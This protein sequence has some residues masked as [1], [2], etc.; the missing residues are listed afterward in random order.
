MLE[1]SREEIVAAFKGDDEDLVIPDL[2]D[3]PWSS[4]DYFGWVHPSGHL[5]F[6]VLQSPNDGQIRGIRLNDR[7]ETLA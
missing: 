7:R 3:I 4:L 1:L 6:V 2:T 5:G